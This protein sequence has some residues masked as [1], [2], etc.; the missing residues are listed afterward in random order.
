MAVSEAMILHNSICKMKHRSHHNHQVLPLASYL[1]SD[2]CKSPKSR[3][4]DILKQRRWWIRRR[5]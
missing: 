2:N 1:L 3:N 5:L 4:V